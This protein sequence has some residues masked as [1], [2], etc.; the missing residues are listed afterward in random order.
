VGLHL[1]AA[2]VHQLTPVLE[3]ELA[4]R[5]G[6]VPDPAAISDWGVAGQGP[7]VSSVVDR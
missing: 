3:L 5:S 7:D 4:G 6:L 2:Q 1:A